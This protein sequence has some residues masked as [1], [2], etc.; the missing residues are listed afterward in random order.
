[1]PTN[2]QLA[3]GTSIQRPIRTSEKALT[4][5]LARQ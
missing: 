5:G 3:T 4:S 2:A 1:M